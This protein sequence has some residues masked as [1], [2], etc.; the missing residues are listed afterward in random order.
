M[1][2]QLWGEIPEVKDGDWDKVVPKDIGKLIIL[3]AIKP[4]LPKAKQPLP[5]E[6]LKHT[7]Q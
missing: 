1:A 3:N 2:G 6:D 4:E 5:E 7:I